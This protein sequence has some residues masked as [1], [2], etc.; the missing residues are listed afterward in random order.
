MLLEW[1]PRDPWLFSPCGGCRVKRSAQDGLNAVFSPD[2]RPSRARSSRVHGSLLQFLCHARLGCLLH[3]SGLPTVRWYLDLIIS[4]SPSSS[5]IL[6]LKLWCTSVTWLCPLPSSPLW[7][8]FSLLCL[9]LLRVCGN[10]RGGRQR[11]LR[12]FVLAGPFPWVAPRLFRSKF[13][14]INPA[15]QASI[16]EHGLWSHLHQNHTASLPSV[17]IVK[18]LIQKVWGGSWELAFIISI[19]G[20]LKMHWW[21]WRG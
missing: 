7:L 15:H 12:P 11:G 1:L 5:D 13:K 4:L 8:S 14:L 3:F 2:V 10:P 16:L 19:Q 20:D 21:W 17:L 6:W 9:I 18:I